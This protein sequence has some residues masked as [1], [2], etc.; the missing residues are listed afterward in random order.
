MVKAQ[1]MMRMDLEKPSNFE[2]IKIA[3]RIIRV[4]MVVALKRFQRSERPA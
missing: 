3:N 4:E 1:S 2:N